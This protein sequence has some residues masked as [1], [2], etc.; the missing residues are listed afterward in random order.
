MNGY[1]GGG[2]L[3]YNEGYNGLFG[4]EK[5]VGVIMGVCVQ[6]GCFEVFGVKVV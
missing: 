5:G 3:G 2:V 1:I 6:M 4:V